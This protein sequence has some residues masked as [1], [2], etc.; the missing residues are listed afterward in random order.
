MNSG[1]EI[2]AIVG[3]GC[4]FPGGADTPSRLWD[5]LKEPRDLLCKIPTDRFNFK[6]FYHPDGLHHGASNVQDSYLLS[7]DIR[8]FDAQFFGIKP[9]EANAIDPQQRLL[10]E[11]VYE[12]V[13]RAG[14]TV[15]G[16]QGS[17][18]AVFV[19]LMCQDYEPLIFRD[20]DTIPTYHATGNARSI[21]SNRISYFFDWHGPSM[22][23]DTA[24]SSSLVAIH[25][26]VQVLRA[27]ESRVAVAA[28]SNLILGPENYI[29]ESKLKMLSPTGRSRMWDGDADGYARGEGVAAVVLKTLKAALEDGDH[30][31]CL[32]RE[33]GIN[34]DG[35]TKGITMPSSTAQATLIRETY[36]K[37]GLD[38]DERCDRPQ[39]FE[40]HGTGT[41]AGDP[42]EAEAIKTAFFASQEQSDST[43]GLDGPRGREPEVLYVGSIKTVVGHT[44]GTAGLA[45]LLKASLA[46]QNATIPP[47]ML[48]NRLNPN[49]KPFYDN[50]ELPIKSKPWPLTSPGQPLRASVNCFGFGGTNAHAILE[51]WESSSVPV[52]APEPSQRDSGYVPF[53]FSATSERSL[54]ALLASYSSFLKSNK[55]INLRNLAWTLFSRRSLHPIRAAFSASTVEDLWTKIDNKLEESRKNSDSSLGIRSIR[56]ANSTQERVLGLFT[57]QGAQWAGMGRELILTLESVRLTIEELENG[58]AKLPPLDRPSWSLKEEL[59]RDASVSRINE[60]AL[61]QPLCTA[62]QI[63]LVD[64][65]CS[66]RIRFTAVVGHSSGEIGAA[67]AAGYI[68]AHDAMRISY[69]RGVH[70]KLACGPQGQEG[71]MLAVGTSFEDAQELCDLPRF[72]NRM[73]VA[74]SNSS[75][76]VTLS[77]DSDAIARAKLCFGDE[78]KFARALVVDK[79]YHSRHMVPCSEPYVRS[80]QQSEIQAQPTVNWACTWFSSVYGEEISNV[81]EQLRDVYWASNMIH[82]VLFSQAVEKAHAEKGPFDLAV[83]IGPHPALKGPLSQTVQDITGENIPYTGLLYRGKTALETFSDAVGFLWAL[84]N[85]VDIEGFDKLTSGGATPKLLKGL[86]TYPWDHDRMYWHES[87]LSKA[88]RTRNEFP[89]ELLGHKTLDGVENQLHWRNILR[90]HEVTWISDH[91]LQSQTVFPAAGYVVTALEAS[92]HIDKVRKIHLIEVQDFVIH[93]ALVFNDE[94]T[95]VETSFTL[96]GMEHNDLDR[97]SANFAYYSAVGRDSESLTLMASGRL[98]VTYGE[99]S[100]DSLPP[101]SPPQ[102]NMIDIEEDRFYSSLAD[103]GY[104][105]T[106]PFRALSSMK[107]KLGI[108]TGLIANPPSEYPDQA[109]MVHPAVLDAS[110]QS[111]ILA[112]CYPN[113]G[114]LWSLHLP[115]S[116]RR[117]KVNPSLCTSKSKRVAFLPFDSALSHEEGTAIYGDVSIYAEHGEYPMVQVEGIHAVPFSGATVENDTHIFSQTSWN[118]AL[119]NGDVVTEDGRATSRDCELALSLERIACFYLRAFESDFPLGHAVRSDEQFKGYFRFMS[120]VNSLVSSGKHFYAKPEWAQ[121][122]LAVILSET[123]N[124]SD[125]VDVKIMHVVGKQMPSVIRGQ[126]TI[127]EHLTQGNLL[128]DFYQNALGMNLYTRFLSR[129]V[130]QITNRYPHMNILEVGAGTGGATRS[131]FKETGSAFASYTFT[132]VSNGFFVKAQEVFSDFE[133][134]MTFKVLNIENDCTTQGFTGHFYDLVVA[135]MVIHA[136]HNLEQSLKNLRR[137]VKPGGYLIMMEMTNNDPIRSGFIFGTLPGWWMGGEEGRLLSPCVPPAQWDSL[138]RKTGYAGID[139]IT[140]D[141]DP[142]PFPASVIVAQAIDD[143]ITLLRQ[144]LTPSS[145]PVNGGKPFDS[146]SIVGG[147]TLRTSRLIGELTGHLRPYFRQIS[148]ITDLEDV[149]SRVQSETTVIC[150][151]ELDEPVFRDMN[152]GKFSGLKTLFGRRTMVWITE[153]CRAD[154]PYLNSTVGFGRSQLCE[155]PDLRLQFFDL[156]RSEKP[157]A[158]TMAEALLRL[159]L[160]ESWTQKGEC[161]DILHSIEP[162]LVLEGGQLWIPRLKLDTAANDRYNSSRRSILKQVDPWSTSVELTESNNLFA[163]QESRTSSVHSRPEH[164]DLVTVRVSHSLT[165]CVRITSIGSWFLILGT[166]LDN[167]EKVLALSRV[168]ESIA[169]AST[170]HLIASRIA[171]CQEQ[172]VLPFIASNLIALSIIASMSPYE[173]LLLHGPDSLVAAVLMRRATDKGIR[174]RQTTTN[175]DLK[176]SSRIFIHPHAS[177]RMINALLPSDVSL[178][179]NLSG[180]SNQNSVADCISAC[181]PSST[182]QVNVS[183]FFSNSANSALYAARVSIRDLLQKAMDYSLQDAST[184]LF[185]TYQHTLR[186]EEISN[187]GRLSDPLGVIDWS[188][189]NSLLIAVKPVDSRPLFAKDKTYWLLGLTGGLGVSLCEW[190]IEHGASHIVLTSRRPKIDQ[191]WLE[192]I[193]SCS[194]V[195]KVFAK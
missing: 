151:A 157:D 44:E 13:E 131:I 150:V 105:Y 30:I 134:K 99:Q 94:E 106:G 165:S 129:I 148:S 27:G 153:G 162:E 41:P 67:Y 2:I 53:V 163:L 11:T 97:V 82:P 166:S 154:C 156:N 107:R 173:T 21:M 146:L 181:L 190:M 100:F 155:V 52:K 61:S 69:Y 12:A 63:V 159:T 6:G 74:A 195:V 38:I 135:S 185:P 85:S 51:S 39:Y 15:E 57:G 49:V 115:T 75:A 18:T 32:I 174:V 118:L 152:S 45:S 25:Q 7:E 84:T 136:T 72:R 147:K 88:L 77:G 137:L 104:G 54:A 29:G 5:L 17:K 119:P 4:R 120:H 83:E 58:L 86:P 130:S 114:R 121:D 125:C 16:L 103:L 26:A 96:A 126:T 171:A 177:K 91:Q 55:A 10:L 28:G 191:N 113:D 60:A 56:V 24:C 161:D 62:I 23:I 141:L 179:L 90:P 79:A 168:H 109:L 158:R 65:L 50:L 128:E 80:L 76:S 180:G 164:N 169:A 95:G 40:A 70:A 123:E 143:R 98:E 9:I 176:G 160:L 110:I 35:K 132:D 14:L 19:G 68:S 186:L 175:T 140:P 89:H 20:L 124:F 37:A 133:N 167:N 142:F 108:A 182:R 187:T 71:A 47:N 138:L 139:T 46:L 194:A 48:F 127:L 42:I 144:P 93:Q 59:L 87:R 116:I 1:K 145:K 31:E 183:T 101:R 178:F 170:E 189:T 66:T 184:G 34:Q 188:T 81:R 92:K 64:L 43:N 112:Y 22:T 111:V 36:A 149:P 8:H 172:N 193:N 78:K 117:I 102:P 33:T 192:N 73:V 122:T 3:S